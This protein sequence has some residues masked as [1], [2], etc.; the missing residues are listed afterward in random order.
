MSTFALYVLFLKAVLTS[1]SGFGSVP[2]VRQDLVEH[3]QVLT[4]ERLNDA[5]ALSQASPGPL[6][7][8]VVV[9]GYFVSGVPGAVAG[10]LALATPALFSVA[11]LR[12]LRRGNVSTVLGACRGIVISSCVLMLSA[13][14]QLAPHAATTLPLALITTGSFALLAL[15]RVPPVVVVA[16]AAAIGMTLP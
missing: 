9:V 6:G 1:F 5:I 3:R 2:M 14:A 8:Y 12:T 13:G 10:S 11:L 16:V 7:M 15:T 4:D